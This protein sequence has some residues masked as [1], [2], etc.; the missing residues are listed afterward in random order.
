MCIR[1][2]YNMMRLGI[3]R[4]QGLSEIPGFLEEIKQ[5]DSNT[6]VIKLDLAKLPVNMLMK[7][8]EYVRNNSPEGNNVSNVTKCRKG[9]MNRSEIEVKITHRIEL[10][11][12]S[13]THLTLP[14]ICSV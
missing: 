3:S 5:Q 1:D 8:E 9:K 13:Y 14:T 4:I 6:D 10:I 12:V 2:R 11:P 7:I